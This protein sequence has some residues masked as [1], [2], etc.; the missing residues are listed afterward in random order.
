[1]FLLVILVLSTITEAVQLFV[2][3]RVFNIFDWIANLLGIGV[4]MVI[5]VVSHGGTE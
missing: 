4:G 1:M 2:P 3:S 5:G